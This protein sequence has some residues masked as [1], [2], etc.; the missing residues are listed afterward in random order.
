MDI[1][2]YW[3][4]INYTSNNWENMWFDNIEMFQNNV[5]EQLSNDE[6]LNKTISMIELIT[7]LQKLG[8]YDTKIHINDIF[9]LMFYR[10]ECINLHTF[11]ISNIIEVSHTIEP[12]IGLLRDPFSICPHLDQSLVPLS[13]YNEAHLQSKR[14]IL[15]SISAPYY[16]HSLLSDSTHLND[17]GFP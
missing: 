14:F 2:C 4:F 11:K 10:Y 17:I 15:L 8:R 1:K 16:T 5:C 9:S 13:I 6:N 12:L 7:K 3:S